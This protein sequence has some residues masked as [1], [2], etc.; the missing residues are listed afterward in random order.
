MAAA[1]A[2]PIG[3]LTN[4][5]HRQPREV[6][7]TPPSSTPTAAREPATDP[8]IPIALL[9]SG[10]S[11]KVAVT[12]DKAAGASAAAAIPCT[13]RAATSAAPLT[14]SPP[15]SEAAE[16]AARLVMNTSRRPSRS[17]SR[18]PSSNSPP[19]VRTYALTTQDRP[20][21]DMPS[22]RPIE[23]SATLTIEESRMTT[24]SAVA[25]TASAIQRR[26]Y[27]A[28]GSRAGRARAATLELL[29]AAAE[30]RP[31]LAVVD[32]AHWLDGPSAEAIT[33]AARRLHADPIA[34][35]LAVRDTPRT[36]FDG[37]GFTELQLRGLDAEAAGAL[38]DCGGPLEPSM[39]VQV[40]RIAEGNPLALLELPRALAAARHPRGG[41]LDEPVPLTPALEDAQLA[42]V[43]GKPPA[44][45]SSA[46]APST[47][48][49]AAST[50][51]SA[52]PPAPSCEPPS[53]AR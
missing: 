53:S 35:V 6:V 13:A 33:F 46:R 37:A 34:L 47:R 30:E 21:A 9:R 1:H 28:A 16:N 39:R 3:T 22:A 12:S 4:K 52:S 29:A 32:D 31:L 8:Q 14:A 49:C 38:L 44:R 51:N 7:S 23:G 15:A 36:A 19:K 25:S 45:C 26:R 18:P 43:P 41:P 11:A 42:P 10:P 27:A 40:L 24:K 2:T 5:I 48:T 50:P 20:P 17:A